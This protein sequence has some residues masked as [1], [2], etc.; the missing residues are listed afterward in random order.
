VAHEHDRCT[1]IEGVLNRRE[2]R[3]DALVV[4]DFAGGFVL[5]DV[6]VYADEHALTGEVEITDGFKHKC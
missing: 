2:R 5:G 3:N 6:E 1:A 4:G